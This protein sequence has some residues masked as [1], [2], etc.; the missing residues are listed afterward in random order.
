MTHHHPI[1]LQNCN[2]CPTRHPDVDCVWHRYLAAACFG[3]LSVT[4]CNRWETKASLLLVL[5][6]GTVCLQTLLHATHC[7]S[8]LRLVILFTTFYMMFAITTLATLNSFM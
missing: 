8:L 4:V 5:S 7:H 6:C 2:V 1:W 3:H